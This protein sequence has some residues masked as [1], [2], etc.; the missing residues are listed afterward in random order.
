[1]PP[2]KLLLLA[3]VIT[4]SL[5]PLQAQQTAKPRQGEGVTAFL[6]RYGYKSQ[7]AKDEFL[8]LNKSKLT[9]DGGLM[10][11]VSY[12]LPVG[13]AKGGSSSKSNAVTEPLFGPALKSVAVTSRELSGACLYLVSGH[14]GP[15][16]GAITKINGHELHEDEYA[17]DIML[18]LARALIQK[19]AKV[20]I[21]IQ[22]AADGIRD[23]TYLNNSKRETC[24]GQTI[25][26]DQ[27]AR[28]QQRCSAINRLTKSDK[29]AYKRAIFIHIDSRSKNEQI[30]VFFYHAPGSNGGKRLCERLHNT[31]KQNYSKFQPGRGFKG[32]VSSRALYVLNNSSPVA[33]FIELGNIQNARNRQRIIL[34]SNR[35]ALAEWICQGIVNDYNKSK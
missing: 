35:Q 20:H 23:D 34:S 4:L 25:P 24:C 19:G 11:G 32:S 26:L 17:Y 6:R 13:A 12:R 9:K 5:A 21:I 15:D 10:L 29:Q 27:L 28:L 1:M 18:R 16:P 14:G 8:R 30:D 31:F 3:L 33:A 7:A 2:H 22:D